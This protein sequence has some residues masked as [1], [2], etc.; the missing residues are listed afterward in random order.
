[1]IVVVVAAGIGYYFKHTPLTYAESGTVV[2]APPKSLT[3]PNPYSILSSGLTATAGIIAIIAMSPQGQQQ[4]RAAGGTASYDAELVNTYNLEYPNFSDPFVTVTAT[5]ANP[6]EAHQTFTVVTELLENLLQ[7]RQAQVGVPD[8]DRVTAHMVGDSGLVPEEP[9]SK[10]TLAG[11]LVLMIIAA[12]SVANFFER[13]P[14]RLR[15][16]RWWPIKGGKRG[17]QFLPARQGQE[18]LE[19]VASDTG[20][21]QARSTTR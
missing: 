13:H 3:Y 11:L 6:A 16:R 2:F 12:F 9:S 1:M 7:T 20:I 10:R 4:V 19:S 5:S 21:S 8:V 15:D 14:M 18:S 17:S